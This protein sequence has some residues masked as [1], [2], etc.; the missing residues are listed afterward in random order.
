MS[1]CGVNTRVYDGYT[2]VNQVRFDCASGEEGEA[3]LNEVLFLFEKK[4]KKGKKGEVC[5]SRRALLESSLTCIA[6]K[7]GMYMRLCMA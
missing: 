7:R 3:V 4:S 6:L 2:G 5:G 1:T